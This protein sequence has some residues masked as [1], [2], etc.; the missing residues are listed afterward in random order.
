MPQHLNMTAKTIDNFLQFTIFIQC[1]SVKVTL[2]I[3]KKYRWIRF[4]LSHMLFQPYSNSYSTLSTVSKYTQ[5]LQKIQSQQNNERNGITNTSRVRSLIK[6]QCSG[7][8]TST[9]PHGYR[10][11]RTL[12][13][14]TSITV[15]DPTTA[16]GTASYDTNTRHRHG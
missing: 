14:R 12:R 9:T 1:M 7:F 16:N 15:F 4:T 5:K 11:P 3:N 2:K 10:R 6:S 13:P 8:S